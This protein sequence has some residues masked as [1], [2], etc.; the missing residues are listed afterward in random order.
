MLTSFNHTIF[1]LSMELTYDSTFVVCLDSLAKDSTGYFGSHNLTFIRCVGSK[2]YLAASTL[3]GGEPEYD[4]P[5]VLTMLWRGRSAG[6]CPVEVVS[7]ALQFYN[8]DADPVEVDDLS[9]EKTVI[10]VR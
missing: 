4:R 1:G 9:I 5:V 6:V 7:P 10:I 3:R 2:V 8:A